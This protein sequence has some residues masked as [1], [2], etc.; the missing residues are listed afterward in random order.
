MG[1]PPGATDRTAPTD[2]GESFA[3]MVGRLVDDEPRK[4]TA[5]A[6]PAKVRSTAASV[7]RRE[8][9]AQPP[10]V[11][12]E[13]ADR[14][15]AVAAPAAAVAAPESA[16]A[17]SDKGVAGTEDTEETVDA[18]VAAL[19][20]ITVAQSTPEASVPPPAVTPEV[21]STLRSESPETEQAATSDLCEV[22]APVTQIPSP[23]RQ[24]DV[25]AEQPGASRTPE[26]T[27]DVQSSRA[28]DVPPVS[29]RQDGGRWR[30]AEPP[31]V[32]AM[33]PGIDLPTEDV[34]APD[35]ADGPQARIRTETGVTG[36]RQSGDGLCGADEER[37]GRGDGE[38]CRP[39]S[40]RHRAPRRQPRPAR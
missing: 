40:P 7:V 38:A 12:D 11:R 33:T 8:P 37:S 24:P 27:R 22:A 36:C 32:A 1:V 25:A 35:A 30:P 3:S 26:T 2:D 29:V 10:S 18:G 20:F 14:D 34:T 15:D 17:V 28:S 6:A 23:Q 21:L 31:A 19:D 9:G 16:A 5:A 39:R 13:T 4:Q